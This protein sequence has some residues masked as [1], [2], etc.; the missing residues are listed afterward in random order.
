MKVFLVEYNSLI[1]SPGYNHKLK[2]KAL[3][4]A[5]SLAAHEAYEFEA[6]LTIKQQIILEHLAEEIFLLEKEGKI[7]RFLTNHPE[8]ET[9]NLILKYLD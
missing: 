5:F 3:E 9:L 2:L 6:N 4:D 8:K 7:R 1:N